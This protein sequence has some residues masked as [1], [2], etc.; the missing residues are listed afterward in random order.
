MKWVWSAIALLLG[1]RLRAPAQV[2]R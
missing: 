1:R 2:D